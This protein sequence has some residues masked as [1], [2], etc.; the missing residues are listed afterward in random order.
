MDESGKRLPRRREE[1][2][3]E[4]DWR[5]YITIAAVRQYMAL[6]GISGELEDTNP[7]FLAAQSAL[8]GYSLTAR[9]VEG[10]N[11]ESGAL[12]YRTGT[13]Q[14]GERRMRLEFTVM[15]IPRAEGAL[16]QLLR[17]TGKPR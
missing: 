8:G 16:P 15:P 9:V 5:W 2:R 10:K 17:V 3:R 4:G 13:V 6:A 11:T 14:V 7:A 12:I 1:P